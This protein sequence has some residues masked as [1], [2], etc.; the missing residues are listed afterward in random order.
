[1]LLA[2]GAPAEQIRILP[3]DLGDEEE[4]TRAA[5]AALAPGRVDILINN[6]ATVEPLVATVTVPAAELRRRSRS[7]LSRPPG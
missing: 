4:R 5:A 6:T 3:A 7:T 2:L 1:M